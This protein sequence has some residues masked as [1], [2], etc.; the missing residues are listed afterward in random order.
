MGINSYKLEWNRGKPPLNYKGGFF[1]K[2]F[3]LIILNK[4]TKSPMQI[5][6]PVSGSVQVE[7]Y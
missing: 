1:C 6:K 3:M 7:I 5:K 2:K 4:T